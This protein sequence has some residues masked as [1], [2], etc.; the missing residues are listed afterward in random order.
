MEMKQAHQVRNGRIYLAAGVVV[1][2]TA[3]AYYLLFRSQLPWPG[4]LI[5]TDIASLA[6]FTDFTQGTYPSFAFTLSMGFIA[7]ALFN[8]A[9]NAVALI[10]VIG[11]WLVGLLHEVTLGT[12]SILDLAAGTLGA[13]VPLMLALGLLKAPTAKPTYAFSLFGKT[14][15]N[16]F[17][18]A[19]RLK[20]TALM[21]VS[22]TLATG[23]SAYEPTD[24][25]NCLERDENNT[26]ISRSSLA[27][28]VYMSYADL[29]SAVRMTEPRA[30]ES[31]SRIYLYESMLFIN[32]RNK[33]IHIIDNRFP[34]TPT[35]IGFIEIPGNTELSIRDDNLYAD[36]YIDLVTLDL[37][38]INNITE[39]ARQ[40]NIF[41]YNARQ[42]IPNNIRLTSD[43]DSMLG[44]VVGHQ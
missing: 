39:I 35:Q 30:L 34:A 44:V 28:P 22:A 11:I 26:C 41:P 38:D 7:L 14:S 25:D 42:N 15:G 27:N 36:S 5:N 3:I 40:E 20:F 9:R 24:A 43:I 8:S 19:E 16:S 12:F 18:L 37:S 21:L 23:T 6:N 31:V 4:Y 29:R 2:F 33:G 1:F 13:I 10:S 17:N 32:D